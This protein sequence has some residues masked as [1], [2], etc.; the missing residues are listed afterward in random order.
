MSWDSVDQKAAALDFARPFDVHKWSDYPEVNKAV[1]ALFD[2]LKGD[3]EFTGNDN[4]QKKHVKVVALDLYAAWLGHPEQYISLHRS[5]NAY[6][7]DTRYNKLHISFLTVGVVDALERAEYVEFHKG[8]QNRETGKSAISRIRATDKLI[9]LIKDDHEVPAIAIS[10]HPHTECI[11]LRD[12]DK[13]DID[14]KDT[15]TT[16]RMRK[17]LKA[18]N[19]LLNKTKIEIPD[20]EDFYVLGIDREAKYLINEPGYFVRRIFNNS[21]WR[22]G[23]RFHGGWWQQIPG[24]IRRTI[25]LNDGKEAC[26]EVDYSGLH[27][28]LLYGMEDIDYWKEDGEDP[29]KLAGYEESERLRQLLKIVLLIAINA[30]DKATAVNA[31]KN[32]INFNNHEYGWS[33]RVGIDIEELIDAFASRHQRIAKYLFSGQGIKLQHIDSRIAEKVI[34]H[35]TAKDIPVLCVH[36]SFLIDPLH[37]NEL[38]TLMVKSFKEIVR[39]IT[40]SKIDIE[41]TMKHSCHYSDLLKVS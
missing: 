36:D 9:K 23:G 22:D 40:P 29:Y 31:I 34:E 1:N 25:H 37:E 27:I 20:P 32:E 21:S 15:R 7:K 24:K 13:R 12:A 17:Q 26:S 4:L 35:F 6:T 16:E 14:Y 2:D 8:Y 11:I 18:Y 19:A 38:I 28:V 41:A 3:P 30:K 33:K 39:D 5:P 10:K